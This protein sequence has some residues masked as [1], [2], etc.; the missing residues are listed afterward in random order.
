[1]YGEVGVALCRAFTLGFF[2]GLL[3]LITMWIDYLGYAT[4]HYCQVMVIAFCG[5]IEVLMLYM[6][7]ND[8]GVL[9]AKIYDSNITFATFCVMM[10][11]S[12]VKCVTGFVVYKS[13]KHEFVRV[14]GDNINGS[15][16]FWNTEQYSSSQL[17][18]AGN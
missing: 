8:N 2:T 12:S 3:H 13:F 9:E 17:N 11:F 1:M 6:N 15:D 4:M 18:N 16:A 7:A 14:Y 5:G 10:V